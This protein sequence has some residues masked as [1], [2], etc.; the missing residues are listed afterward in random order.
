MGGYA[1]IGQGMGSATELQGEGTPHGHGFISLVNAYQHPTLEDIAALI[2][3][4]GDKAAQ[5]KMVERIINL[6]THLR[7]EE[8]YDNDL[9]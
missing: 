1:G 8:H 3:Q 6:S 2:Q 7:R 5:D 9:H 4:D